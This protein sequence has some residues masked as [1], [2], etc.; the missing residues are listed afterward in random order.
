MSDDTVLHVIIPQTEVDQIAQQPRIDNLELASE[1]ASRVNVRGVGLEA[2]VVA[3]DLTRARG[4][5]GGDEKRVAKTLTS[6]LFAQRRPFPSG[7]PSYMYE[8]AEGQATHRSDGVTPHMSNW[9]S[10]SDA[11]DP[12]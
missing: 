1:H 5:H 10:P 11:G 2:L 9:S 6:D 8:I 4:R 12:W 3:E 7:R